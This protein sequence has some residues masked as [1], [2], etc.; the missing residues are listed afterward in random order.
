MEWECPSGCG[1]GI[2]IEEVRRG[3]VMHATLFSE[4]GFSLHFVHPD[5]MVRNKDPR[6]VV[7]D[8]LMQ[9]ARILFATGDI[10]EVSEV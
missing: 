1:R 8:P 9:E 10:K 3:E 2:T 4:T 6:L 7:E 5:C